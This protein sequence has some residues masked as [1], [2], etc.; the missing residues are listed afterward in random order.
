MSLKA[1]INADLL[2]AMKAKEE[3]TMTVLRLLKAAIMK[4]EVSGKE[5]GE[6]S[7]EKVLEI[8]GRELKQRKDSIEAYQKGGR[9]DLASKEEAELAVLKSYQP[10]QMSED[11]VREVISQ[12]ITQTGATSK[13]DFGKVM[14]PIMAQVKGKTD[15]QT[16]SRLVGE[17]LK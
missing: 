1:K 12:V 7:D 14:G 8:I 3:T 11:D 15:G 10:E 2:T 17:L 9:G 6:A 5:K 4:F 16:V 13:A